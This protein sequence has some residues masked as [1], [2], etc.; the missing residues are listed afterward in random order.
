MPLPSEPQETLAHR[1]RDQL[2]ERIVCGLVGA[3]TSGGVI[4]FG[5]KDGSLV[6]LSSGAIGGFILGALLGEK[7]FGLWK[8]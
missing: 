1:L 2:G 5:M 4:W 7:L 3:A 8:E 6:F